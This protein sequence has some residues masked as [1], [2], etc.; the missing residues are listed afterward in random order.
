MLE[1]GSSYYSFKRLVP[2]AFNEVLQG[3][4]APPYL[5]LQELPPQLLQAVAAQVEIESE[6]LK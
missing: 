2:G 4:P 1:S 6:S 5:C 3:Q